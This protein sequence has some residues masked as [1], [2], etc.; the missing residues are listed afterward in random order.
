MKFIISCKAPLRLAVVALM[1]SILFAVSIFNSAS[2]ETDLTSHPK[3]HQHFI[4]SDEAEHLF[5]IGDAILI[6]LN[7]PQ[8]STMHL[9]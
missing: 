1:H 9:Q 5:G 8:G 6:V 2:L 7:D 3:T 4:A